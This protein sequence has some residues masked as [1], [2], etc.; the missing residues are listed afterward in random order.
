MSVGFCVRNKIGRL[1]GLSFVGYM[2]KNVWGVRMIVVLYWLCSDGCLGN[3]ILLECF[4][5]CFKK[6]YGIL[7]FFYLLN[8]MICWERL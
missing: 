5:Y 4:I 2:L 8:N 1:I 6:V 7:R 3:W